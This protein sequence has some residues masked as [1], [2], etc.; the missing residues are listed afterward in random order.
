MVQ[1]VKR[2]KQKIDELSAIAADFYGDYS[3]DKLF[4]MV[5]RMTIEKKL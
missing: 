3:M 1:I 5:R 2:L 4:E